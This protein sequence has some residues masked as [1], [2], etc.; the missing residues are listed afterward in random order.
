MS[1]G[2]PGSW[3]ESLIVTLEAVCLSEVDVGNQI[4]VRTVHAHTHEAT[5]PAFLPMIL[6]GVKLVIHPAEK[7]PCHDSIKSCFL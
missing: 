6:I 5:N 1:A 2:V 4:L 3:H 7:D